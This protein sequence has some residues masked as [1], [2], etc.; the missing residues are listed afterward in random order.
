MI[1]NTLTKAVRVVDEVEKILK[2]VEGYDAKLDTKT[3]KGISKIKKTLKSLS[4]IAQIKSVL[5]KDTIEIQKLQHQIKISS[6]NINEAML[7]LKGSFIEK[8]KNPPFKTLKDIVATVMLESEK[9]KKITSIVTSANFD[10]YSK[11]IKED[12]V[13]F[14][15]EY[16]KS[17]KDSF[18]KTKIVREDIKFKMSFSPLEVQIVL[19]NLYSNIDKMKGKGATLIFEK[20][21]STE[22]VIKFL[23]DGKRISNDDTS[24]IFKFGFTTTKNGSGMGLYNVKQIIKSMNSTIKFIQNK[25]EK[26]FMV[27]LKK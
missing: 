1:E 16:V 25:E 15:V 23:D 22:L 24:E 4:S 2:D 5:G 8:E 6:N 26:G 11:R 17:F 13:F 19:D 9:I 21:S 18:V 3:S 10:L 20:K 27:T 14:I 12:I 7:Y